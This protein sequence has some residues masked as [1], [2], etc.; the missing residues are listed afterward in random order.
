VARYGGDEFALLLPETSL[1]EGMG[2]VESLRVKISQNNF[3][4]GERGEK[5]A[6]TFSIGLAAVKEGDTPDTL[7]LRADRGLYKSKHAGRNQVNYDL[8][9][10]RLAEAACV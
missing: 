5:A 4:I 10:S 6:V 9:E 7:I 8:E 2:L 3:D 1:D